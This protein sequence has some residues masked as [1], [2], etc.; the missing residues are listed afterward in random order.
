MTVLKGLGAV[1]SVSGWKAQVR[2]AAINVG[3]E[4]I[5]SLN[6][7]SNTAP[8][9]QTKQSSPERPHKPVALEKPIIKDASDLGVLFGLPRR[10]FAILGGTNFASFVAA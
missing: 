2:K 6:V 4:E 3:K 8:A 9:P 10:R 1:A 7:R 5:A